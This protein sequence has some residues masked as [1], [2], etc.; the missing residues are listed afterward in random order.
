M[1]VLLFCTVLFEW[2]K[3]LAEYTGVTSGGLAAGSVLRG[4][5]GDTVE[6]C[7]ITRISRCLSVVVESCRSCRGSLSC[8]RDRG[9]HLVD[10]ISRLAGR[11]I[12]TGPARS[13]MSS[14][15]DNMAG[16]S[17]LGHLSGLRG[18]MFNSG[19]SRAGRRTG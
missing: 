8:L 6:N 10:H 13:G 3:R 16:F 12:L 14:I 11:T 1:L 15:N 2:R 9:R 17:V 4:R 18:R 7:G 5:F 19:L